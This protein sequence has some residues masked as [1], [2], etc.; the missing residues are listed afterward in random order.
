MIPYKMTLSEWKN[1]I[2][3]Q[4]RRVGSFFIRGRYGWSPM[5]T[6]SFD[7]YLAGV[8]APSLKHMAKVA[9]GYPQWICEEYNL[10]TDEHGWAKDPDTAIGCWRLWL[11]DM[12]NWFEWYYK[13]EITLREG[14]T[15]V[16]KREVIEF[17][18][19]RMKTFKTIILPSFFKHFESLWD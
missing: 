9:H 18:E 6:W 13:D 2:R 4:L 16:E 19:K 11:W 12:G 10:E 14:M 7:H 15:D 17:Y 1:E 3:Y 8:L 5:D